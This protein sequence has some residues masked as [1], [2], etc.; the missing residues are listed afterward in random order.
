MCEF[1]VRL[2]I[3]FK[4]FNFLLDPGVN[5]SFQL[6][7]GDKLIDA[8]RIAIERID[9]IRQEMASYAGKKEKFNL[10]LYF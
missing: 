7:V 3:T 9:L 5:F 4:V 8:K 10:K 6:Y 1:L 2:S